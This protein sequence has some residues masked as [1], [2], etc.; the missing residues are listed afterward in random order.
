MYNDLKQHYWWPGVKRKIFEF[1]CQQVKAEH[2]ISFSFVIA[3]DDSIVEIEKCH[4]G[5]CFRVTVDSKKKRFNMGSYG[6]INEIRLHSVPLPIIYYRDPRFTST[7]WGNLH[8][9]LGTRLN[10]SIAFH[11]QTDGHC[12]KYLSLT[13]FVYNNNYQPSIKWFCT[14]LYIGVNIE[15]RY[16]SLNGM[17]ESYLGLT[18]FGKMKKNLSESLMEYRLALPPELDRIHKVFHVSMFQHYRSDPSQVLS[19]AK[20]DLQANL[21]YSAEPFRIIARGVKELRKFSI[22]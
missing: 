7:F 10:F 4:Y 20:I 6:Q 8:D 13:E 2:Q 16:I 12:E 15:V 19:T 9:A 18:L 5:F 17:K 3:C 1:V 14:R 21:T 22:G 11:T